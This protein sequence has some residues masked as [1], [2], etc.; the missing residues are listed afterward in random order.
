MDVKLHEQ[1]TGLNPIQRTSL[2]AKKLTW[3]SKGKMLHS[4][5]PSAGVALT[6]PRLGSARKK[7]WLHVHVTVCILAYVERVRMDIPN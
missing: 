5:T 2:Y 4:F 7:G 1:P 6:R 3:C